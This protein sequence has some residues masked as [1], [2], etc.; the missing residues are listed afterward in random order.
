MIAVTIVRT[1]L[2]TT[3]IPRRREGV[4]SRMAISTAAGLVVAKTP[5]QEVWMEQ[6]PPDFETASRG[7]S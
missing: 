1:N 4:M 5:V 6:T 2:L 7:A 3:E